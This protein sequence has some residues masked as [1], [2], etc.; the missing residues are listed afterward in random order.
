MARGLHP[1]PAWRRLGQPAP[2]ELADDRRQLHRAVQLVA[3][4]AASW[5]PA[6]TDDGHRSLEW[7]PDLGA[8]ASRPVPA[9]RPVRVALALAEP[10]LLLLAGEG[11]PAARLPL[12]GR[13][14]EEAHAW[15]EG[16]VRPLLPPGAAPLAAAEQP[17][18]PAGPGS[19][20]R[21]FRPDGRCCAELA[22]WYGNAD[23]A[24]RRAAAGQA[25]SSP[26][27]CWPHHFDIAFLVPLDRVAGIAASLGAGM[28]PG[29]D[30]IADPYWYVTPHPVREGSPRPP[31]AGGGTWHDGGWFGA[32]LTADALLA[33]GEE[34]AQVARLGEFLDSALAAGRGLVA[35][36]ADGEEGA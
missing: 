4:G 27:V 36:A 17:D 35:A 21:P 3:A 2:A 1:A 5:L 29:D 16:Q 10:A 26:V 18:L 8:L 31:L 11:P 15:L 32:V 19:P 22:R 7:L 33:A 24:L 20:G 9:P 23:V 12:A 13:P 28:T 30:A 6:A 34:T 14:P 25:G